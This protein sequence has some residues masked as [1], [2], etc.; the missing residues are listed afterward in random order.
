MIR[1]VYTRA[2][3]HHQGYKCSECPTELTDL[4][5][6]EFGDCLD[7]SYQQG[8]A[9]AIDEFL[10]S[11]CIGCA[12]LNGTDCENKHGCPCVISQHEVLRQANKVL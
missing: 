3:C 12:Y 1:C 10:K 11:I 9:D 2:E 5:C 4:K 6:D 8:R 7:L